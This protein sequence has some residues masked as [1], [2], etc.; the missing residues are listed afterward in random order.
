M[1]NIYDEYGGDEKDASSKI[2][3]LGETLS[4]LRSTEEE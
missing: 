3:Y 1:L 4:L 2:N